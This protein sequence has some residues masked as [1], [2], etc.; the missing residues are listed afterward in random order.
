MDR[1]YRGDTD[2]LTHSEAAHYDG[3]LRVLAQ[4]MAQGPCIGYCWY[5]GATEKGYVVIPLQVTT[6]DGASKP[7][8]KARRQRLAAHI[9]RL[10]RRGTLIHEHNDAV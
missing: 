9:K 10:Y 5:A 4:R 7:I 8:S 6:K 2:A 1:F 3:Y